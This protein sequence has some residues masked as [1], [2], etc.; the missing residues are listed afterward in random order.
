M[1]VVSRWL[2]CAV[3]LLVGTTIA[4]NKSLTQAKAERDQYVENTAAA[5]QD[6]K[7]LQIDSSTMARQVQTLNLTVDEYKQYRAE[8]ASKIDQM[9]I[10]IKALTAAAKHK[11]V[12]DVPIV[13]DVKDSSILINEIPIAIQTVHMQNKYVDFNGT[14]KD[15]VFSGRLHLPVE[16]QQAVWV[17]YKWKFLCFHGG[18]KNIQQTISS[19]NPYVEVSYSEFITIKN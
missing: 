7:R 15:G 8:D 14:I 16:L 4:L 19:N 18:V 11:I 2:L 6:S 13:A 12:V 1:N 5:L 9:G 3:L 17:K 10:K